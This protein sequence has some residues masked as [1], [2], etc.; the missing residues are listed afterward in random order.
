MHYRLRNLTYR[1]NT[2]ITGRILPVGYVLP[3]IVLISKQYFL[4]CHIFMGEGVAVKF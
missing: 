3:I 4:W 1:L 2:K